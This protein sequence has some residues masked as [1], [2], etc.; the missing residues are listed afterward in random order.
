MKPIRKNGDSVSRLR[1]TRLHSLTSWR[2]ACRVTASLLSLLYSYRHG[3]AWGTQ[4]WIDPVRGVAY[5]LFVQRSNFPNSD[6]SDVRLGFQ[7]AA[8]AALAQ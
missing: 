6:G 3:G 7:R 2:A 4:A 5:L 8:A 1:E